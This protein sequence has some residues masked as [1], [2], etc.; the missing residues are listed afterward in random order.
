MK[1]QRKEIEK[2]AKEAATRKLFWKSGIFLKPLIGICGSGKYFVTF[3]AHFLKAEGGIAFRK[4]NRV[5]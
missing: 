4:G 3:L 2:T 1:S 5:K